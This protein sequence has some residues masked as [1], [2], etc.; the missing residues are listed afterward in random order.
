MRETQLTLPSLSVALLLSD[1]NE[2]KEIST[3]FKKLGIIPHFY[4]DLKTF[5]TGTLDRT[6][7][8]CIVDVKKMSE[9]EFALHDHPLVKAEKLPLVF[10]YTHNTEP[11]LVSTFD[12][13][14]LGLLKKSEQGALPGAVY[15]TQLRSILKRL[16]HLIGLEKENHNLKATK[17]SLSE[18][19]EK[20]ELEKLVMENTDQYQSMVKSVCLQLEEQRG[21]SDF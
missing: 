11:L 18:T 8:L 17:Q 13:F 20:L 3:V 1:L 6:P 14:H 16:N 9:G 7:S 4:E 12:F 21:E 2:V 10:Y 15:D 5:W 19:I